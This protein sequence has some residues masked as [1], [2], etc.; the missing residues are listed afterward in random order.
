MNN[1]LYH[2]GIKGMKWGVRRTPEQLGHYSDGKKR[3][4]AK[5]D[6][7]RYV[8]AKMGYGEGAGT[9][10]KLLKA[11]LSEKMKDST[12]KS[13]FDNYVE[14]ANYEKAG[15]A[16]KRERRIRDITSNKVVRTGAKIAGV[17][18]AVG[19]G[20]KIASQNPVAQRKAKVFVDG[21][22]RIGIVDLFAS[23]Q[24]TKTGRAYVLGNLLKDAA[25]G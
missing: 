11:E 2:Y 18:A 3:K 21:I 19:V 6:A 20:Y 17:A 9:R 15:R 7:K 22:K 1:Q 25:L 12:Y 14:N 10:R 13:A 5:K 4:I 8:K 16:A 23:G 24:Y